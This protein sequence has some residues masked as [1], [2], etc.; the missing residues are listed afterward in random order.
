[1]N[2]NQLSGK[3][4]TNVYVQNFYYIKYDFP[5]NSTIFTSKVF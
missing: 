4:H 5:I 2:T 3:Q 1:M